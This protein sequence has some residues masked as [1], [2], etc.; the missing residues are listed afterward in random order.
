[1]TIACL[2]IKK[3][4]NPIRIDS[5]SCTAN[6]AG[7]KMDY[8]LKISSQWT[9]ELNVYADG[10]LIAQKELTDDIKTFYN[11]IKHQAWEERHEIDV[12]ER[13]AISKELLI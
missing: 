2:N 1:M 5:T 8:K 6:C 4:S 9:V 3:I 12:A 13:A 7:Y 10:R 11:A